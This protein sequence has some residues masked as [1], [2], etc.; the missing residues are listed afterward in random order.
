M[1]LLTREEAWSV[2]R[3]LERDVDRAEK[4]GGR[5]EDAVA[6]FRLVGRKL[7]PDLFPDE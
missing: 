5:D 4:A 7:L 3:V 1:I 2:L 6:A